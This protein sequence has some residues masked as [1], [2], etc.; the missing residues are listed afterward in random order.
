MA[1]TWH[2]VDQ[3]KS[4]CR[5]HRYCEGQLF[6]G[7]GLVHDLAAEKSVESGCFHGS[8]KVVI[9]QTSCFSKTIVINIMP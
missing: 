6:V 2:V 5:H 1:E 3:A 9:D 8:L 7:F 4:R